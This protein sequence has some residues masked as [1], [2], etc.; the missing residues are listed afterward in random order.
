[1]E[2]KSFDARSVRAEA[3]CELEKL[4]VLGEGRCWCG[5]CSAETSNEECKK[6]KQQISESNLQV[7][8]V[9]TD[10]DQERCGP[11]V[12]TFLGFKDGGGKLWKYLVGLNGSQV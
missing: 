7:F 8:G 5:A 12:A 1:M 6:K 2:P 10:A 4:V 11:R 9:T 3:R